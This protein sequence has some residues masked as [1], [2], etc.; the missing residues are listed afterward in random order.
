MKIYGI[1]KYVAIISMFMT[2]FSFAATSPAQ[3][4]GSGNPYIDAQT[5]LDFVLYKPSNTVGLSQTKFQVLPCSTGGVEWI[6]VTFSHGKKSIQVMETAVG[7]HCSNPGIAKKLPSIKAKGVSANE[8]VFCNP[9]KQSEFA[10]CS[11]A[12][13]SH[14]GG[15]LLFNLPAN[16]FLRGTTI[17]IQGEGGVTS[18]ELV[19][20]ANSL[21]TKFGP[22]AAEA[23]LLT[24][25]Y[26]NNCGTPE[27]RPV[28]ITQYCA[29]AGTSVNKITWSSWTADAASGTGIYSV[30]MCN[31]NC[32]AGKVVSHK[33]V[34]TLSQAQKTHGKKYLMKV[35]IVSADSAPL[36]QSDTKAHA[37]KTL[38]WI[39]DFW[40]Q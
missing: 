14:V 15:Y 36:P 24:G 37:I 10:R 20:V 18:Q 6:A 39:S 30:N 8:F 38:S 5:G 35:T 4:M 9:A 1:R 3:A 34:V 27:R 29:D 26:F 33:V 12:D 7:A 23:A 25:P 2:V 31:P 13:I 16:K 32:A 40:R 19:I 21:S 17:Q 11:T 22:T 28:S